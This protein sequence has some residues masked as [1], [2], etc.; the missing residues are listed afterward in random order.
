[1]EIHR[2]NATLSTVSVIFQLVRFVKIFDGGL[3]RLHSGFG[4][5]H[6]PAAFLTL[7]VNHVHQTVLDRVIGRFG[8]V[9]LF[10]EQNRG[11]AV[12]FETEGGG[13]VVFAAPEVVH[14]RRRPARNSYSTGTILTVDTHRSRV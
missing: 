8:G 5:V 14:A 13:E 10:P 4:H 7:G 11:D 6:V 2:Q 9:Q 12:L 3:R 1:M